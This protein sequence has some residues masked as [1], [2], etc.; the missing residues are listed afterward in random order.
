MY[1]I[2]YNSKESLLNRRH[3]WIKSQKSFLSSAS[4]KQ[5]TSREH[6]LSLLQPWSKGSRESISAALYAIGHL[7]LVFFN[8]GNR[9]GD[10]GGVKAQKNGHRDDK[11]LVAEQ[12]PSQVWQ[13]VE[14]QKAGNA[15]SQVDHTDDH[16]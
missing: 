7:V 16:H 15:R 6:L 12:S 2:V 9:C 8:P 11:H 3:H 4:G 10:A 5:E 14:Q 13:M 1:F